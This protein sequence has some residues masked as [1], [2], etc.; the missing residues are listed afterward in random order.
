MFIL[1]IKIKWLISSPVRE[2]NSV[3]PVHIN[4]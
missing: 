3:K 2:K 4:K 1:L